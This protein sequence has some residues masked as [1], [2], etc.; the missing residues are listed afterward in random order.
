MKLEWINAISNLT[1]TII[2]ILAFVVAI[3]T[4]NEWKAEKRYDAYISYYNKLESK[5]I[6]TSDVIGALKAFEMNNIE[7][8]KNP[9]N[10]NKFKNILGIKSLDFMDKCSQ[11]NSEFFH[12]FIDKECFEAIKI[13][14]D[15]ELETFKSLDIQNWNSYEDV[16]FEKIEEN[17]NKVTEATNNV[18]VR[19]GD[20]LK[21]KKPIK[22]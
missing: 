22:F 6:A 5:N 4:K 16:Q 1:L 13:M 10:F 21:N 17:L 2:A 9:E 20:I 7:Y 11:A 15:K 14:R 8:K 19:A 3:Q 12:A 18:I